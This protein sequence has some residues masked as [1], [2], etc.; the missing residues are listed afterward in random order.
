MA[1]LIDKERENWLE[2]CMFIN[3]FS[4][5][6]AVL[7]LDKNIKYDLVHLMFTGS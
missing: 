6:K 5:N 4:N 3:A 7:M 1:P 2:K